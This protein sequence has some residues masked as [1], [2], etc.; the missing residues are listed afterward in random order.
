M[1][2]IALALAASSMLAVPAMAL[3][4]TDGKGGNAYGKDPKVCLITYSSDVSDGRGDPAEFVTKAQY[5]PLRIAM[6]KD[7]AQSLI[8]TYGSG[9]YNGPEVDIAR[10]QYND[11]TVSGIRMNSTTEEA[12]TA[13]SAYAEMRDMD[14]DDRD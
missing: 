6:R 1:K 10:V 12:C 3:E 5:L 2:K 14:D 13:L 4:H 8:V 11:P 7:T 9:G